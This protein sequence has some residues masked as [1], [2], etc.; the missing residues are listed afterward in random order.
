MWLEQKS[1][2][3]GAA[4]GLGNVTKR[5][6][7]LGCSLP[8]VAML[9]SSTIEGLF[10]NRTETPDDNGRTCGIV[11]IL[12]LFVLIYFWSLWSTM[13]GAFALRCCFQ[14]RTLS[15]PFCPRCSRFGPHRCR[16]LVV[17]LGRGQFRFHCPSKG[18]FRVVSGSSYPRVSKFVNCHS[19]ILL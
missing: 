11:W 12:F 7:E 13:I 16:S 10:S 6:W 1:G 19:F 8:I 9:V 14:C 18:H 5:G 15:Y 17:F 3:W 2:T 4:L